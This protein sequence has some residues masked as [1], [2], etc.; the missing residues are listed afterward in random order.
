M[1]RGVKAD[2]VGRIMIAR[3]RHDGRAGLAVNARQEIVEEL[4]GFF[5]RDR[6]VE[7]VARDDQRIDAM[8]DDGVKH[9]VEELSLVVE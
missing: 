1:K 8:L 5:A 6:T 9:L 3:D 4:D 7:Q 2:A